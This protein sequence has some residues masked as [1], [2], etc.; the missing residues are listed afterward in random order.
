M[1][2][3]QEL[4]HSPDQTRSLNRLIPISPEAVDHRLDVL[5]SNP[6]KAE[7]VYLH[8]IHTLLNK[9]QVFAV[10]EA[11]GMMGDVLT[12]FD[13]LIGQE[14]VRWDQKHLSNAGIYDI[15]RDRIDIQ[16]SPP[17]KREII[18]S[19]ALTGE[20]PSA[21]E[22]LAHELIHDKQHPESLVARLLMLLVNNSNLEDAFFPGWEFIETVAYRLT[23]ME[24]DEA[25]PLQVMEH[26]KTAKDDNGNHLYPNVDPQQLIVSC[27]LTDQMMALGMNPLDICR[28]AITGG[29]WNEKTQTYPVIVSKIKSLC[30]T[31][32]FKHPQDLNK[33]VNSYRLSK[34]QDKLDAQKYALEGLH[35]IPNQE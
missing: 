22:I 24:P 17:T 13:G 14:I 20:P 3:V 30:P 19:F 35:L 1:V 27:Q 23:H 7:A 12:H 10:Y 18:R 28:L 21:L 31:E 2:E 9:T 25:T 16:H 32:N 8:V 4:P 6:E 34:W 33:L 11:L 5:F 29:G 26:I 15:Y